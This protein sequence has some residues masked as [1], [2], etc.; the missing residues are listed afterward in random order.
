MA[1][2]PDNPS[3][4]LAGI[5][6]KPIAIW[7]GLL[8]LVVTVYHM[9]YSGEE[10][11]LHGFEGFAYAIYVVTV[12]IS[13]LVWW[14]L[15]SGVSPRGKLMGVLVAV[16]FLS[17][18][19]VDGYRGDLMPKVVFRWSGAT[20]GTH[21][22]LV[23]DG[24]LGHQEI[25]FDGYTL[26]ETDWGDYRGAGRKG[27]VQ[28]GG[29]EDSWLQPVELW[30]IKVG[31]GWSSFISVGKLCW[32]QGQSGGD[33]L[34]T[35]YDIGSGA[36]I[37]EHSDPVRFDETFG[38][39]G[40]RATPVYNDGKLWTLGATGL[41]NCFDAAT[42]ELHWTQDILAGNNAPNIEWGM[43]ASP[44]IYNDFVIVHPGGPGGNSLVAYDKST[45]DKKWSGGDSIAS[46]SSPQVAVLDGVEQVVVH[47]GVG[48]AGHSLEDGRVLWEYP[49]TTMSKVNVAQPIVH[50]DKQ[51]LTSSGYSV[52]TVNV[53]VSRTGGKWQAKELW[54]STRLKSKFNTLV[55]VGQY[56]YG[57]D[58]GIM[59]CLDMATG[60]RMWKGG[61]YGYGQF[62]LAGDAFVVL[63]E[64]GG[65]A[66]VRATHEKYEEIGKFK[67][68]DSKTWQHPCIAN[69]RLIVRNDL[70]AVCYSFGGS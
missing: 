45:G 2:N 41:L 36:K 66:F 6:W 53:Q 5:R 17:L 12:G 67:A 30:R 21:S 26:Q 24:H 28:G 1:G 46:Y 70:V 7:L 18:F 11:A 63:T 31:K 3:N 62:V 60:K 64:T 16:V 13:I 65:G 32:T 49:W 55:S 52:G 48:L 10:G 50:S 44:L 54:R 38:G 35:A 4:P 51:I 47:N 33:E 42:G 19:K 29:F 58:E 9:L 22:Q 20:I 25:T 34:V 59:T 68:L 37:W 56:V 23:G 14:L 8:T 69:G 43:T 39:P 57:L 61:R 27:I 15:L 40:P